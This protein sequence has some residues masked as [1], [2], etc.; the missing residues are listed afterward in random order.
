MSMGS[1]SSCFWKKGNTFPYR[2][3]VIHTLCSLA[4]HEHINLLFQSIN[5]WSVQT[6]LL[7]DPKDNWTNLTQTLDSLEKETVPPKT[8]VAF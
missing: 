1:S 6:Q 4:K 3:G 2:D 5:L 7:F 8:E